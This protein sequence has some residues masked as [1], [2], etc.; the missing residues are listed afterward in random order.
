MQMSRLKHWRVVVSGLSRAAQAASGAL[1]V[2][3]V[4][5]TP[6][7]LN[8]PCTVVQYQS[9]YF[10]IQ[11]SS[12]SLEPTEVNIVQFVQNC[13]LKYRFYLNQTCTINV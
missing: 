10:S 9:F 8:H 4:A 1:V 3:V 7:C 11:T 5:P 12:Y 6:R 13:T 2:F